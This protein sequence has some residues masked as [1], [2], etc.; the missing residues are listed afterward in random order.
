M[1]VVVLF[2]DRA[3]RWRY[4]VMAANHKIV[5]ASQGYRTKWGAERSAR[6]LYGPDITIEQ[7]QT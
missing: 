2:K 5:G 4:R 1:K 7:E 3:G 6:K